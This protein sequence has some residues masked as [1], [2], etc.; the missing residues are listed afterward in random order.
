MCIFPLKASLRDHAIDLDQ[1]FL[2]IPG[3]REIIVCACF[4][5]PDGYFHLGDT[6]WEDLEAAGERDRQDLIAA[7][8]AV[9]SAIFNVDAA[10]GQYY[11]SITLNV[12]YYLSKESQPTA[13]KWNALL[14]ASLPLFD[15]GIIHADVRQAMRQ[16][17]AS[18]RNS[19]R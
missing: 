2:V 6:E 11:P 3:L 4:Q 5:R 8:A 19:S 16:P 17:P 14:G 9:E 13:Q 15:A 1:E 18:R 12:N 10:I 7:R